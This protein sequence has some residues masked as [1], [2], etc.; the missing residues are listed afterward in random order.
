MS[1]LDYLR[2]EASRGN[3]AVWD[4]YLAHVP[5]VPADTGDEL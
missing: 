3:R 1:S 4:T 2:K 5:D